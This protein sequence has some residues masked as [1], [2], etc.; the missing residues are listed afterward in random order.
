MQPQSA[1][2]PHTGNSQLG[3]EFP[4]TMQVAMVGTDG[5]LLASDLMWAE[6]NLPIRASQLSPKIK[7]SAR[8]PLNKDCH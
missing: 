7:L 2:F 3:E 8:E 5:I 1:R 6:N 4:M